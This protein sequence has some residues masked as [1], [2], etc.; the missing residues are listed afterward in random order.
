MASQ[1]KIS[2]YNLAD[3]KNTT[4]DA[5]PNYLN[6]LRFTQSHALIDTRLA[7]GFS[8]LATAAACF[9]WDYKLGFDATK[10]YTAAAVALYTL[11]N[12]ALTYWLLY[13]ERGTVYVGTAPSGETLRIRTATPRKDVPEYDVTVEVTDKQGKKEVVSFTR[14]F[15]GWFDAAGGFVAAPFQG[16]LAGAVSVVG[17][18]D[19]KRAREAVGADVGLAAGAAYSAEMLEVLAKAQGGEEA[20][21][22]GAEVGK[23][24]GKRRK[25]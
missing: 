12:G 15:E 25:A 2:V 24:G 4:D 22:T 23:K 13:V 20:E 16:M 8:A 1:E 21:G 9:F 5:I 17:R 6:S 7:L 14:G 3:L 18:C 10:P 19:P 11:L